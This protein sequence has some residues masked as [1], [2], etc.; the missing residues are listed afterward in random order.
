MVESVIVRKLE[1]AALDA[2]PAV[3]MNHFGGWI[4][5]WDHGITRRANSVLPLQKPPLDIENAIDYC[6]KFYSKHGLNSSF[7]LNLF[8]QPR[9]LD[10]ILEDCGFLK[11]ITVSMMTKNLN[12]IDFENIWD[13]KLSASLTDS[14]FNAYSA[15]YGFNAENNV[16]RKE[17][18]NRSKQGKAFA[19]VELN[20]ETIGIG[21]A[22]IENGWVGL[23]CI[24]TKL[25][26]RRLGVATSIIQSLCNW[27]KYK[28]AKSC[29][30]PVIKENVQAKSLYSKLGFSTFY[31]YWYRILQ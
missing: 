28:N 25:R 23:L 4:L 10:S 2:W 7:Q 31:E 6:I 30:L 13:V 15:I 3:E 20:G 21:A 9:R 16:V 17:I 11:E 1:K 8:S 12:D 24:A 27:A 19:S 29:Y 14:W 26:F 18:I 22:F 5:R